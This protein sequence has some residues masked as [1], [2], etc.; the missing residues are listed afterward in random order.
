M[1]P[2]QVG[3]IVKRADAD[4]NS[5]PAYRAMRGTVIR[6]ARGIYVHWHGD[7]RCDLGSGPYPSYWLSHEEQPK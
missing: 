4:E 3:D 6:I 1:R 7:P 5:I 2:F